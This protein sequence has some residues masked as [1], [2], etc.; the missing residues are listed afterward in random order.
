M[1]VRYDEEEIKKVNPIKLLKILM[2]LAVLMPPKN[3]VINVITRVASTRNRSGYEYEY[4]YIWRQNAT[5]W[6]MRGQPARVFSKSQINKYFLSVMPKLKSI[7]LERN[8]D[9]NDETGLT[10]FYDCNDDC[11]AQKIHPANTIAKGFLVDMPRRRQAKRAQINAEI[12]F[13][14][15]AGNFP[16]GI[17][18]QNAATRFAVAQKSPSMHTPRT[19]TETASMHTAPTHFRTRSPPASAP[20]PHPRRHAKSAAAA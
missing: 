2:D 8:T 10:Y 17:E 19:H 14:P 1:E 4:E 15:P 13:L 12:R 18:Y 6:K 3:T 5:E 16:G 9:R 7:A 11:F 20:Q